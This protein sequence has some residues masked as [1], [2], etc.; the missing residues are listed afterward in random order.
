M[1]NRVRNYKLNRLKD[2]ENAW[3]WKTFK[4]NTDKRYEGNDRH[5]DNEGG[6]EW[7]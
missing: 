2:N 5:T 7:K 6:D 3:I 4:G 1:D